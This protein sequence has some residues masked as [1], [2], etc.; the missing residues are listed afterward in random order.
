MITLIRSG[1]KR[2]DKIAHRALG[3]RLAA[4]EIK[5]FQKKATDKMSALEYWQNKYGQAWD[6]KHSQHLLKRGGILVGPDAFYLRRPF[7]IEQYTIL[8]ALLRHLIKQKDE[9]KV[10]DVACGNGLAC[11]FIAANK[12]RYSNKVKY[13]GIDSSESQL[14]GAKLRN[15]WSFAEFKAGIWL[16]P[17]CRQMSST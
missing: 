1:L 2:L 9:V 5:A 7:R 17:V 4:A 14:F 10:L 15:P 13:L 11:F 3:S 16:T 8:D 12:E 6:F